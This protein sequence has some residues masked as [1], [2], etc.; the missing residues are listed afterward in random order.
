MCLTRTSISSIDLLDF[1]TNKV[2]ETLGIDL[3][4]DG[5][6]GGPGPL[7]SVE[8]ATHVDFNRDGIIGGYRPPAGGGTC[9]H[10]SMIE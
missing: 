6:V 8:R 7:A 1:I 2:E 9:V 10:L 5:R 3:N 4:N